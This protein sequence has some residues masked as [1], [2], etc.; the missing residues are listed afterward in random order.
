MRLA[1]LAG[2][3]VVVTGGAGA[4]LAHDVE[5]ISGGRGIRVL[6]D[7]TARLGESDHGHPARTA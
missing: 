6:L 7:S 5:K 2:R 3:L 4:E 1:N